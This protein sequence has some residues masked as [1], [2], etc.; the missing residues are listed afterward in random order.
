MA[1]KA[2][3]ESELQTINQNKESEMIA[4]TETETKVKTKQQDVSV[5]GSFRKALE[6]IGASEFCVPCY[7]YMMPGHVCPDWSRRT[8]E[9]DLRRVLRPVPRASRALPVRA[10]EGRQLVL[11]VS[12]GR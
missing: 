4:T 9:Q 3:C 7:A 12:G 1:P 5:Y 11:Q 6:R 10:V 8:D 2:R